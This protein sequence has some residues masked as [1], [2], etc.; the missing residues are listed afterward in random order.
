MK[1]QVSIARALKEKNRVAGRL[2][3]AREI[4]QQEN[5]KDKSLPRRVDVE[6]TYA[7]AKMLEARLVAI[8]SAIAQANNPI[9]AKIIELDEL[10]SEIAFLNG[11]NVKEGRFEEVSYGNK[12]V[13]D[14]EA[15]VGQARVLAE[16]AELQERADVLQDALDEFNAS[17]KVEIEID[18]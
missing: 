2:A 11:L 13:R 12:I 16:V 7:E 6:A 15:V 5:S 18:G 3:K 17:T 8:K 10:K 1:K 14:I 4:I 9:V